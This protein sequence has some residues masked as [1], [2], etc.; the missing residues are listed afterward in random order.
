MRGYIIVGDDLKTTAFHA[1][2]HGI[3]HTRLKHDFYAREVKRV[4]QDLEPGVYRAA[5]ASIGRRASIT[6][7]R[8]VRDV[9]AEIAGLEE[10]AA[11]G[12]ASYRT[13]SPGIQ[14]G[15]QTEARV[16]GAQSAAQKASRNLARALARFTG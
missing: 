8:R 9:A 13:G 16:R 10:R 6:L 11:R 15:L 4:T 5:F 7:G 3:F 2:N 14:G 1:T 12:G